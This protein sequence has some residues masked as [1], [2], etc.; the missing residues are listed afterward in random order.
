M[1]KNETSK[2]HET[3]VNE[4]GESKV[5]ETKATQ[6]TIVNEEGEVN[7]AELDQSYADSQGIL[8]TNLCKAGVPITARQIA[9]LLCGHMGIVEAI[10]RSERKAKTIVDEF[11]Q[12]NTMKLG[13]LASVY[14]SL[15]DR[16]DEAEAIDYGELEPI[17]ELHFTAHKEVK[18]YR[19][20][21][22]KA[23]NFRECVDFLTSEI[24]ALPAE[25]QTILTT[26]YFLS[27]RVPRSERDD[28]LQTIFA[29]VF[30]RVWKLRWNVDNVHFS[31]DG[32]IGIDH[33][34]ECVEMPARL[35][36]FIG[37]C[38][39]VD[40]WRNYKRHSQSSFAPYDAI[41]ECE[42]RDESESDDPL[43]FVHDKLVRVMEVANLTPKQQATV[44]DA[45]L[46]HDNYKEIQRDEIEY[47]AIVRQS[48]RILQSATEY[49]A[50]TEVEDDDL[51]RETLRRLP[52]HIRKLVLRLTGKFDSDGIEI[53][54]RTRVLNPAEAKALARWSKTKGCAELLTRLG[55]ADS[56]LF[57]SPAEVH[58]VRILPDTPSEI[59]SSKGLGLGVSYTMDHRLLRVSDGS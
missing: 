6:A 5:K 47:R 48:Q 59:H 17:A 55:L 13:S 1:G 26:A 22:A 36:Y 34:G 10:E 51:M 21:P 2:K 27:A 12:V 44:L 32:L 18:E 15:L 33:S 45:K 29:S 14:E 3:I 49:D 11:E 58:D 30:N 19:E 41:V 16:Q 20:R 39:L 42:S 56:R 43:D 4:K 38:D 8:A 52:P 24:S 9:R 35:A 40:Y 31:G 57:Q 46:L 23:S 25:S 28:M 53:V 7:L 54:K 37:H 50:S